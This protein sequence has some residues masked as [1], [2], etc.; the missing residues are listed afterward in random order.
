MSALSAISPID[1]RY[2]GQTL[3]LIP[4]FSEFALIRY[5]TL[6]ECEYLIALVENKKLNIKP[7]S[8]K[9]K[10]IIRGFYENM[11]LEEAMLV[12]GYEATTNH[13]VKSVEYYLK[14]KLKDAKLVSYIEWVHFALTSEDTNNLSYA[15]LMQESIRDV[16]VPFMTKVEREF[17]MLAKQHKD[18]PMLSR[19]HGQ[20]ASPTTLGKEFKVFSW[21]LSRQIEILRKHVML[22][23]VSGATGN[24]HAH[25]AAFPKVDWATFSS[26]FIKSLGSLRNVKLEQNPL[27]TQIES[28]DTVAE[29]CD[30]L[31][32][33]NTV[34]LSTDQD[35]W[36]YIS[37]AW[38]VQKPKAGE[39]GSSTMP[40][41]VNPIDFE[42][43][44]GNFGIANALLT[45]FSS[46]LP[47][48]RLQ[49][50]LTDST[51]FR[52][53]GVAFAHSLLGYKSLLKGLSKIG[54]SEVKILEDLNSHPE[55]VSEGIQTILRA[56]GVAMPYEKLK[57]L[58]RG[59]KVTMGDIAVFID[60]LEVSLELKKR[61]KK[62][63]PENY[64]GLAAKLAGK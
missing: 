23:K 54:V 46:K 51:V 58:T 16:I 36:R 32:R 60:S 64:I 40:H 43:S 11:T 26:K 45:H 57:E 3:E 6:M 38:I 8:Q 18:L 14:E 30:A 5:R 50:D 2:A 9:E 25:I 62:I 59:K 21:R 15:L 52:N 29:V 41:K 33:A 49:R 7:L 4:Y 34:L 13:D 1:G 28:H 24:Y 63:T 31:R 44:E 61:L 53:I 39:V 12:K 56:E 42:N 22:T 17:E 37:D 47:V 55:I 35:L 27:T 48:S 10:K 20:S 19:T